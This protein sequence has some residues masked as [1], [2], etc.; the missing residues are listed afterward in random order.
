MAVRTDHDRVKERRLC[1]N[2]VTVSPCG[3]TALTVKG[4]VRKKS[5][6]QELSRLLSRLL[7]KGLSE[8][9]PRQRTCQCYCQRTCQGYCQRTCQGYCQMTCQGY[10]QRTCQGRVVSP[11]RDTTLTHDEKKTTCYRQRIV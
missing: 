3:D 4:P 5:T 1:E 7:L 11:R 2:E 10:C 9:K 8:K 6:S